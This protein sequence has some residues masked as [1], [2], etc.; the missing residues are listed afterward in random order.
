[1]KL[2]RFQTDR[3]LWFRISLVFFLVSW[4]LPILSIA[5][6]GGSG[7][8]AILILVWWIV[9]VLQPD[10]T[11]ELVRSGAMLLG[12]FGC[13]SVIL[14]C[15]AAWF[16]H[17]AIIIVRTKRRLKMMLSSNLSPEP[18]AVDAGSSAARPMPQ[19]GGGLPHDR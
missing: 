15:T 18:A 19:V 7:C 12:A 10:V 4:F 14:S 11:S 17:C 2:S 5:K 16:L 9:G 3:R 6:D 8:P 1:M 13:V